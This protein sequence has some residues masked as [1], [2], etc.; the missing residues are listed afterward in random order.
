MDENSVSCSDVSIN[1]FEA[2]STDSLHLSKFSPSI[3]KIKTP[4]ST[5][6]SPKFR[7]SID[8]LAILKPADIDET[9]QQD[10]NLDQDTEQRLQQAIDQFFSQKQVAPSPWSSG[11]LVKHVTFSP[12]PPSTNYYESA[13]NSGASSCDTSFTNNK[14]NMVDASSQTCLTLPLDF[15]LHALLCK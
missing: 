8:Q 11:K 12:H 13:D 14:P 6:K 3:F 7:W 10:T 4:S 9:P 15:D 5:K 1:P 2:E